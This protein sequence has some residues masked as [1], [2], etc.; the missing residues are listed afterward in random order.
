MSDHTVPILKKS[1][2]VLRLV[3]ANP[4]LST[5]A[6][7]ACLELPPSTT[8]RILRTLQS[9]DLV[10][11]T[12]TGTHE[13]S[14]GLLPLLE[15]LR[16]H[17]LLIESVA[18]PLQQLSRQTGLSAKLTVRQGNKAVNIFRAEPEQPNAIGVRLGSAVHL[19]LGSSGSVLLSALTDVERAGLIT[20][21]PDECW[22]LQT[23]A[24]VYRRLAAFAETGACRDLGHFNAGIH[25]M[26]AAVRSRTGCLLGAITLLGFPHDF[27]GAQGDL[28]QGRLLSAAARCDEIIRG[29][30]ESLQQATA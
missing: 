4:H 9:E 5:K 12:A 20:Q 30:P 8:Y 28:L 14:F 10:R 16:R 7:A 2:G 26:S 25:A 29:H 27:D 13:L 24:D 21:A 23:N 15:P 22:R 1:V 3:S 17:D 11:Q 18:G 19:A 6:I